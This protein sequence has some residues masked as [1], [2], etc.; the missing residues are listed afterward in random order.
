MKLGEFRAWFEGFCEGITDKPN[1][2]QWKRI[3]AKVAEIDDQLTPWVVFRDNYI[4][5]RPYWPTWSNPGW[6]STNGG[7]SYATNNTAADT[8]RAA[9]YAE[10]KAIA[11]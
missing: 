3:K 1:P 8:W 5:Y 9:G 4:P 6:S 11:S 7:I 10:A 2:A